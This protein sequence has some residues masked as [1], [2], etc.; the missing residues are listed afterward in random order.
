[1]DTARIYLYVD[2]ES[3]FCTAE[4]CWKNLH[5]QDKNLSSLDYPK[6]DTA[7]MS[8]QIALYEPAKFFWDPSVPPKIFNRFFNTDYSRMIERKVYFTS[9]TGT[10]TGLHDAQ[11]KI[12]EAGFE[13]DVVREVK[14]LAQQRQNQLTQNGVLIKAKGVDVS[15]SVRMLEDAY[16]G[17][18]EWCILATSDA[19]YLPV[20]RAVRR[21]GKQVFVIGY[22]E[23]TAKDS[24]F[25]FL[26]ET[27]YEV[28]EAFMRIAYAL[29]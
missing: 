18:Y 15:L 2:G 12:R 10:E 26:P 19:D 8:H 4:K 14:D 5:G 21:M 7:R 16:H 11:V 28:G 3:H 25:L 1:M 23:A 13:P 24:P 27:F 17:N 9:F 20:I 22:R 6:G 29:K